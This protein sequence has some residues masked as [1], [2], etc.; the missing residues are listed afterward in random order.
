MLNENW[1]GSILESDVNVTTR[2]HDSLTFL[3]AT[4]VGHEMTL[5][6][7]L[8]QCSNSRN[9]QDLHQT[10][11]HMEVHILSNGIKQQEWRTRNESWTEMKD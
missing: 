4:W 5:Y 1:D 3:G 2:I 9:H 11:A 10:K 7:K 6:L 8:D